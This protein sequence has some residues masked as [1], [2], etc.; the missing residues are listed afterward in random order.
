[1]RRKRGRTLESDVSKMKWERA[2]P[3]IHSPICLENTYLVHL[4]VHEHFQR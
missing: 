3:L 4:M 1:M 2:I